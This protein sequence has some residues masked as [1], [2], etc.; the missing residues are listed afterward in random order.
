MHTHHIA[1]VELVFDIK[2]SDP[3]VVLVLEFL[4]F[5]TENKGEDGVSEIILFGLL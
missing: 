1:I 3:F 5:S 4:S 2:R